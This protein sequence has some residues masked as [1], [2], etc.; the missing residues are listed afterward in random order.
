MMHFDLNQS[1][2]WPMSSLITSFS[3]SYY[4]QPRKTL[5][6]DNSEGDPKSQFY[7]GEESKIS[8][9]DAPM[10]GDRPI[11]LSPKSLKMN[12]M[13]VEQ[14]DK[15]SEEISPFLKSSRQIKSPWRF[16]IK[17]GLKKSG[18]L[19]R[20]LIGSEKRIYPSLH[21]HSDEREGKEQEV[22]RKPANSTK[23]PVSL[24]LPLKKVQCFRTHLGNTDKWEEKESL[25]LS[26]SMKK[27]VSF[28]DSSPIPAV[29]RELNLASLPRVQVACLPDVGSSEGDA[30]SDSCLV[31]VKRCK[32]L[33]GGKKLIVPAVAAAMGGIPACMNLDFAKETIDDS[34]E[35]IQSD[36]SLS[37]KS[38][39]FTHAPRP[40]FVQ[41]RRNTT[42]ERCLDETPA[43]L[44]SRFVISWKSH[45]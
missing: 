41:M 6:G 30:D 39:P 4:H 11:H 18:T 35:K 29:K 10:D 23:S 16:P 21:I 45:Q 17:A 44:T 13:S 40:R 28:K 2:Y 27:S 12:R 34:G 42:L 38:D 26:G 22:N 15:H 3:P 25:P 20:D 1:F 32:W 7:L 14:I 24:K 43:L 33:S 5:V 19:K 36:I 37:K 31:G 9:L 8:D